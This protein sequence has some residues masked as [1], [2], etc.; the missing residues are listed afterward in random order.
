L[1][2]PF[3]IVVVAIERSQNVREREGAD[4]LP[5]FDP[6]GDRRTEVNAG[7]NPGLAVL[8]GCLG[9]ARKRTRD[10]GKRCPARRC[11]RQIVVM[12]SKNG[13][14]VRDTRVSCAVSLAEGDRIC[15]GSVLLTFKAVHPGATTKTLGT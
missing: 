9:E 8:M 13:T 7:V 15:V 4:L 3:A 1:L 6:I 10:A 5:V 12:E 14:Y 11:E 2:S